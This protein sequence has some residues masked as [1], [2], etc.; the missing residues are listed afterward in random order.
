MI[1]EFLDFLLILTTRFLTIKQNKKQATRS[2]NYYSW[3]S[4]ERLVSNPLINIISKDL[5]KKQAY[6]YSTLRL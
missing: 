5:R 3:N 2:I 6:F 4:Y 1:L